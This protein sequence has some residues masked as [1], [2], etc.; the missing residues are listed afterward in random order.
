AEVRATP[1]PPT[2]AAQGTAGRQPGIGVITTLVAAAIY[3]VL[4]ILPGPQRALEIV[5]PLSTFWLGPLLVAAVWWAGWPLTRR[6]RPVAGLIITAALI[7]SALVF[8]ALAQAVV[9]RFDLAGMFSTTSAQS[10]GVFTT[11]PFTIP[12]GALVFVTMVQITL[13]CGGWPFDKLGPVRG[14]VAALGASWAIALLAYFTLANWDFVPEV[15]QA[16]L[17][18]RNPGG[19]FNALT[20]T[21]W[22]ACVACWQVVLFV[23]WAGWP[24]TALRSTGARVLLANVATLG[25][26]TL[27]F[28]LYLQVLDWSVPRIAGA[29]GI[30]AGAVFLLAAAFETWPFRLLRPVAAR[31]ALL[32]AA[33]LLSVALF[34]GLGAV[35]TALD[36]WDRTPYELWLAVAGLNIIAP[37][38]ILYTGIWRRW[39][40]APPAPTP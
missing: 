3:T 13:V 29:G 14:G 2:P 34:V 35:A 7:V 33:A 19:P 1:A 15:A 16:A 32:G 8:T 22:I 6:P 40:F 38:L 36:T 39:P 18:L 37:A 21:S 23:L 27:T 9:G 25:L 31:I 30:V 26:G 28:L 17:G 10:E 24:F 20:M 5:G 11:F 12:L 4:M